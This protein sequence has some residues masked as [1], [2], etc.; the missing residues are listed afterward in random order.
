MGSYLSKWLFQ[1]FMSCE[2]SLCYHGMKELLT[3]LK[4]VICGNP[5][6]QARGGALK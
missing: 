3:R 1:N 4:G 6:L 5:G 2:S